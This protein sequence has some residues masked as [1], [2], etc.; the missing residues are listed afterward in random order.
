M[1]LGVGGGGWGSGGL[2][3]VV[4]SNQAAAFVYAAN[5]MH[6]AAVV[7]DAGASGGAEGAISTP[8]QAMEVA[9]QP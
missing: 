1:G 7:A 8:E 6:L 4:D 2:V 3:V 9:A 5:V